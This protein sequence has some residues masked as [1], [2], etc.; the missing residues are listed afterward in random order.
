MTA[1]PSNRGCAPLL[2]VCSR[3]PAPTGSRVTAPPSNRGSAPLL[4]V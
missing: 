1:P 3:R 2:N 4:N